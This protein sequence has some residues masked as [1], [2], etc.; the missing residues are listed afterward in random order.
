MSLAVE[1]KSQK[2][3][4]CWCSIWVMSLA[5]EVKSQK[6]RV[7]WCS[8]WVMSLAV[9]VRSQKHLPLGIVLKVLKGSEKLENGSQIKTTAC[10]CRGTCAVIRELQQERAPRNMT[11]KCGSIRQKDYGLQIPDP[12]Y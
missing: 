7:C 3:R 12:D 9:E 4:V 2:H 8:N 11:E 10:V 6:H 1:V 5:V